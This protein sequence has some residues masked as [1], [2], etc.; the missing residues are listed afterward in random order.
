MK[1]IKKW[2]L[3][4]GTVLMMLSLT[5]CGSKKVDL[6]PYISMNYN[7]FNGKATASAQFDYASFEYDI[8]SQWKEKEKTFE[9]LA[10][11]TAFEST[12]DC[13]IQN[14]ENL[15]NGDEIAVK[16]SW[17]EKMAKNLGLSLENGEKNFTVEGLQDIIE[18]DPFDE[19]KFGAGKMVDVTIEGISP[20]LEVTVK[21]NAPYNDIYTAIHYTM[22]QSVY[23]KNGDTVTVKVTVEDY[24]ERE[25]Y[26]LSR[27][28]ITLNL[29]GFHSFVTDASLLKQ[30]DVVRLQGYL[31]D[32][33]DEQMQ[34]DVSVSYPGIRESVCHVGSHHGGTW[35]EPA[36]LEYGYTTEVSWGFGRKCILLV[37]FTTAIENV[38]QTIWEGEFNADGIFISIPDACGYFVVSK[39]ELDE[40][41]N[42]CNESFN[43]E[44]LKMFA[45]S[46]M[47]EEA[48]E[49][50]YGKLEPQN[51]Q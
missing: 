9:K 34:K 15:H 7:G 11:L 37:P 27:S 29:E 12:I 30:E 36:F 18:I 24:F 4:L 16:V 50:T 28:E 44:E 45:N 47:M 46:Q 20:F 48:I 1:K 8:M 21:N 49:E 40:D 51:F 42:V 39:L 43:I 10:E 23:L 38:K 14:G 32:S 2:L 3:I 19:S 13:Q 25:G 17:N 22:D 41:G 5:A 33:L 6:S 35:T 31:K 26:A